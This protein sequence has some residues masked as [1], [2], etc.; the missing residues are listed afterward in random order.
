MITQQDVELFLQQFKVKM[1]VFGI[2][3]RNDRGKN[4]QTL[5]DL[6][7]SMMERL[8]VVRQI[9]VT[10]YSEGPIADTLNRGSEM[11]VFGKDVKG[12]EVYVKIAMGFSGSN[13]ICISFHISEHP[14]SYPFRKG[15]NEET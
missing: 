4:I 2:V 6:N 13:T 3:F 9:E 14:M 7:I 12:Q 10:D 8:Q 11:W 1:E 15:R 5:V